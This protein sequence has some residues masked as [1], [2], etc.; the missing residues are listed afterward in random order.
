MLD[1]SG[2]GTISL[3]HYERLRSARLDMLDP[4]VVGELRVLVR[5][6]PELHAVLV[7]LAR[8]ETRSV[9]S[10]ILHMLKQALPPDLA[11]ELKSAEE[12]PRVRED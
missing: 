11:A 3:S 4:D 5:V 10:Q 6:P 1:T 8:R 7:Q 2:G 9:N 12:T